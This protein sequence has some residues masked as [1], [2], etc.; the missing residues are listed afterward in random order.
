MEFE[1]K[2]IGRIHLA[3]TNYEFLSDCGKQ[4]LSNDDSEF[5][6]FDSLARFTSN[7]V[8]GNE[9]KIMACSFSGSELLIRKIEF[10]PKTDLSEV[11]DT[12][13][14]C[15]EDM[16]TVF[17]KDTLRTTPADWR[18][19][20]ITE[21]QLYDKWN[22]KWTVENTLPCRGRET[23]NTPYSYN[24]CKSELVELGS[25]YHNQTFYREFRENDLK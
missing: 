21:G 4:A 11:I 15:R 9:L 14:E 17:Y 2:G 24:H 12:A 1:Y 16:A 5:I 10:V 8:N 18:T 23:W 19:L 25:T 6:K 20:H 13:A 22:A 7:I 3:I